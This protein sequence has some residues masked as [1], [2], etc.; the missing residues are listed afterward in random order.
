MATWKHHH[1]CQNCRTLT[2]CFG[3]LEQNLDGEPEITC[4][5]FHLAGGAINQD[6]LCEDCSIIAEAKERADLREN[7]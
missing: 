1:F 4:R 6:F 2:E 7:V 3:D 5:E